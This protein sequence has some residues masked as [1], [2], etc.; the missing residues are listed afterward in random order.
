MTRRRAWIEIIGESDAEGELR[1]AYDSMLPKGRRARD[2]DIDNIIAVHSL[3]PRTMLEH[4]EAYKTI[5]HRASGL[6]RTEREIMAVVV[7]TLNECH[8]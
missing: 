3:H 1:E 6:S 5:M 8:Y 7:S 2:G 4:L